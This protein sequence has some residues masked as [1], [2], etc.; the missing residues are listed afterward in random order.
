MRESEQRV[1]FLG[2]IPILGNLFR[3]R[4][5]DKVKT[6][7]LVFIRAKI[8]RNSAQMSVETNAKYNSIQQ[9]LQGNREAGIS[10]MPDQERPV[11]P[12]LEEYQQGD[13]SSEGSEEQPSQDDE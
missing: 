6:N 5:T 9:I 4:K 7:L 2:R 13:Q 12:P 8:L 11:L 1:P 10:L 3:S